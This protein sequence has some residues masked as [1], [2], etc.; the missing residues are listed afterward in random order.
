MSLLSRRASRLLAALTIGVIAAAGSVVVG[1]TADAATSYPYTL[2]SDKIRASFAA[3]GSMQSLKIVGDL[4]DTDYLMNP[5]S[6]PEQA[7]ETNSKYRQWFGNLMFSYANG[8]GAVSTTGVGA[9]PWK[10]AWTSQSADGRTVS[11]TS[12]SVTVTHQNSTNAEG[13]KGFTV[14][15]TY[16]LASDGS[17][18]WKQDVKN[19]AATQLVIGDWGV[20]VPGN[21]LWRQGDSIYE[22]RVLTHSYVGKNGSYVTLERPSGQGP[23]I[24]MTADTASGSGFEYQDR[25][26]T[27]EVGNTSW[28]WN[29]ANESSNIKG[30]NIYY[31]HSTA[32]QKTNRGYLSSTSV[33]IAPGA[34]KSYTYRI[35][36]VDD[37]A[38]LKQTMFDRGLLDTTVVPGLIVPIDRRAE[39]A[40]RIKGTITSVTARN[41]N[42]LKGS[43]PTNPVVTF[44]RSNGD[45]R[46]YGMTFDRTQL[47]ANDVTVSYTDQT[48][49]ARQSV[50]QFSVI[51]SVAGLLD[52]HAKF[53]VEKTQWKPSDGLSA[54]DI[55]NY[56]FDDWMMNAPDGSLATT[57]NAPQGRRN[58]Y[59]GYYGLGDDWGLPH[60]QFL[61]EKL[62]A[63]PDATQIKALDDYLQ[64]A[65]WENL[66]G[67][68][69][70]S[71]APKYTVYDFWE[72]GK[73][74]SLNTTPG[75]RGYAYP[76]VYNTF[77]GMYNIAKQNP[78]AIAYAHPA[79]WYLTTAYGI[80]KEL[81]EGPVAYNWETGLMGELSTPDLIAALRAEGLD[82]QA[83]DIEAKMAIKYANFSSNAY[84]YGS[85]YSYDNTGE[86]AVYTLAKLNVNDDKT[87]AL[88][89]MRDI[90]AKTE[91]ARGRMPVWYWYSDPTTITG[92]N[93]WQFQYSASLA[94][95]TMDDYINHTAALETGTTAITAAR[96]AELQ[97]LNYAGK[98]AGLATINSG[99]I[100]N[101]PAN[102]GAASWSYQ[103]ERGNLGTLG[104]GG[105]ANVKL[106][107]GWRGM[108]GE[109]DL[110]LW[111]TLQTL[112][113]DVVTDDPIFGVVGYG[114]DVSR[115]AYSTT[116]IPKDGL[117][118]RLNLV[119]QQLSVDLEND[120]YSQAIVGSNSADLRLDMLNRTGTAHSGIAEVSGLAQGSYAVIVNGVRQRTVNVYRPASLAGTLP[121]P[122]RVP[123][124]APAGSTYIVHL[125]STA[126]GANAAPT[127]NAGPDQ[128]GLSLG[129]D[130]IQLSGSASDDGLGSPNG[131]LTT[132]WS[133]QSAPA[134]ATAT[135]AS[136][137]AR[138]TS[139][140][141]STAG[142]YV[143]ALRA[144]DGVLATTDT[145]SVT[146]QALQPLPAD[147]VTYTFDS[148]S[149]GTVPDASGNGNALALKGTAATATDGTASV[150]RLNGSDGAF[151]QLPSD[152]LSRSKDLT[153][154]MR[155]KVDSISTF[156]RLFDFGSSTQKYVFLTPKSTDGKL[157]LALT[158]SGNGAET[159]ISTNFTMPAGQWTDI[160]VTFKANTNGT[161]TGTIF[162]NGVQVGQNTAMPLAPKDLGRTSGNF[163]GKSQ[164]PDPYLAGSFDSFEIDG[165]VR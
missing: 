91:A 132:Q 71:A 72:Q 47:G 68:T 149:N 161:T 64:K 160:K 88:R 137:T 53:M 142:S 129:L 56:T 81:Y 115:D 48:G 156:S 130:P 57:T 69:S 107:N 96:R 60:G 55:R 140:S 145:V 25:W 100:S 4:H 124:D 148:S 85:E 151:A 157:G 24:A 138:R 38:A 70:P 62:V 118:R 110:G 159:R 21:E 2:A 99:Q 33:A 51:D 128:A 19:T 119:T 105:G 89:V 83:N 94:G 106:N 45:Y 11:A 30:L 5:D 144:S 131:T 87:N 16:S 44:S 58:E 104:V 73:P 79:Q 3:D 32:I 15:E 153:I 77:F 80:F 122:V 63:L 61:A 66:M 95:Y 135:F 158:T 35:G 139:A 42:D 164:F 125:V 98:V 29:S 49:A 27:E 141:V 116:V 143:F 101:A 14:T 93:W 114:A 65:V 102:I 23:F 8:T 92:E 84:P 74:G 52:T 86:E 126:P 121:A 7:R 26:R 17:L 150:L 120:A 67:N 90:V 59:A 82:T 9:N 136:P 20:P 133:V 50:L 163:L 34:T 123:F 97:R 113:A 40:F 54:S 13:V 152:I 127:V 37:D 76:H 43:A 154:S 46:I 28:A 117:Q 12:S 111:G 39:M 134:G 6:A 146:V 155:V 22:T 31:P 147:W 165:V 18:V 36:K 162:A 108:T 41:R 10:T 109:S 1:Q 78:S 75:Y 103:A 112:S